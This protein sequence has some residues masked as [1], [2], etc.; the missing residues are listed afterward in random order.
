MNLSDI[1]RI[2]KRYKTLMAR[3]MLEAIQ[4]ARRG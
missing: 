3:R 2:A 1:E 4:A